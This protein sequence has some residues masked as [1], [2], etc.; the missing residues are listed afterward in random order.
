MGKLTE[1]KPKCLISVNGATVLET[2]SIGFPDATLHIIGD[3]KI[4]VLQ[5]YLEIV[6][7]DFDYNLIKASGYGT[8]AGISEALNFIPKGEPFAISWSDLFY[9]SQVFISDE[10]K[11]YV[12]LTNSNRCR[13]MFQDGKFI[14]KDTT[15]NGVIG[16][17]L[18]RNKTILPP[19]LPDIGEFV[20][21]LS[22]TKIVFSNLLLD[23]VYEIG[24]MDNYLSFKSQFPVSRFFNNI[25]IK[26]ETVIKHS[27]NPKFK[28]L[29]DDEI[30]WYKYMENVNFTGVPEVLSY[31]PLK[32]KRIRGMHPHQIKGLSHD[33]KLNIIEEIIK[34][35]H[36]V[37]SV[38]RSPV[39]SQDLYYMYIIK[40][41]DRIT[42]VVKM[43]KLKPN[44]RFIVNGK[45][46]EAVTPDNLRNIMDQFKR[47]TAISFFCTIHGDPTFSNTF[48]TNKNEIKFIDPRGS[49]GNTKIFGDPRYDLSKLYYSA[50]GN[51]D[52]FNYGNFEIRK[53]F[54][55]IEFKI[56]SSQ[57]EFTD[58]IFE[59][60]FGHYYRDIKILHALIWLSLSG[61]VLN[62]Y[63]A[64]IAAYF[65]GLYYLEDVQNG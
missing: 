40:T 59:K 45:K 39:I 56:N 21:F 15:L 2:V 12:G 28:Y 43:L 11:N 65:I 50:I 61:Y 17:F 52:Q 37:H 13:F 7:P 34:R 53:N 5:S 38:K 18:F 24:T 23:S 54:P 4:D 20:R 58:E 25:E 49:F 35:L 3:Y 42:P 26:G 64:M 44:Q 51:Y 16:L 41:I 32:L 36:E 63:D 60:N 10:T 27:L 48:V 6:H 46:V 62:D 9:R 31:E 19:D 29:L 14:E 47:L 57:F 30:N 55:E 1:N 22:R 8:I 33:D